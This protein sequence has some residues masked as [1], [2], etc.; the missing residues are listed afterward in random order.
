[1]WPRAETLREVRPA[2]VEELGGVC[3][4]L[5]QGREIGLEFLVV[6][7]CVAGD[8]AGHSVLGGFLA[9]LSQ[10]APSSAPSTAMSATSAT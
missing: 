10:A 5:A 8:L 7:C 1:M 3:F 2:S 9:P 4:L 6:G